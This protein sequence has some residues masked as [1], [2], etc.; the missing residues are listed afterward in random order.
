M[1]RRQD[2]VIGAD[3]APNLP[4]TQAGDDYGFSLALGSADVSLVTLTNAY[5]ALANGGVVSPIAELPA[6]AKAAS[7]S[8]SKRVFSRESAFIVTDVLADNNARTRTFD[9]DS[10]LDTR[11]FSAVKTGTSKDMRD[12]W[13][14]GFTSRYTVGVWGGNADG[15]RY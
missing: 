6:L 3:A 11:M 1:D 13:T 14:V 4:L 5:R 10:P 8:A 7:N 15:V 9:F 12:N 2:Q